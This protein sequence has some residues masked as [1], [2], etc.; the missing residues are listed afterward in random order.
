M[1]EILEGVGVALVEEGA[2]RVGPGGLLLEAGQSLAGEGVQG[3]ADGA[4]GAAEIGGRSGRARRRG[5]GQKDLTATDR[6]GVGGS[7]ALP[8]PQPLSG[9]EAAEQ[10][11]VVS[12]HII[13]AQLTLE[14]TLFDFALARLP[15]EGIKR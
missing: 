15:Q 14:K 8:E 10:R 12:Y 1:Q 11:V 7:R 6:E 13:R 3:V 5:H 9:C 2:G 4:G